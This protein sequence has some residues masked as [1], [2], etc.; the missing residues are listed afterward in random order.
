MPPA[1]PRGKWQWFLPVRTL[2]AGWRL[3]EKAVHEGK[4]GPS[5]KVATL[6]NPFDGD[7]T[8]RPVIIFTEDCNDEEDIRR[9]LVALRDLGVNDALAYKTD[10]AT[11]LGEYGGRVS[12]YTSPTGTTKLVRRTPRYAASA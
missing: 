11:R 4:L 12:T 9:V 5:A 6:G 8:R 1:T 10:E 2:D 7:P 3:V